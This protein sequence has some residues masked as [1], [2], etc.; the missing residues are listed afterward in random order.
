MFLCVPFILFY[1]CIVAVCCWCF[2][3][4][5]YGQC[6][7]TVQLNQ[8]KHATGGWHRDARRTHIP[9]RDSFYIFLVQKLR[10]ELDGKHLAR[11]LAKMAETMTNG[12]QVPWCFHVNWFDDEAPVYKQAAACVVDANMQFIIMCWWLYDRDPD[13]AHALYLYC[14]RAWQ[15]LDIH[16]ANDALF[17]RVGASWEYS[18]Q[19]KGTLLLTN[20]LMIQTI[21]CMELIHI[22]EKDA[23]KPTQFKN[24][25]ARAVSTWMPEIYK[26]QETLPRVLAVCFN[27][28]PATFVKSF[29]QDM[30]TEWIPCRVQGP[31]ANTPTRAA[32]IYGYADMHD[33]LV[34]P[35][36]GFLWIVVLDA[37]NHHDLAARWWNAYMH[38]HEPKTLYDVYS[39]KTRRPLRRAFL[40]AHPEHALTI[41]TWLTAKNV[42]IDQLI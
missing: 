22:V 31:V 20:V 19:H 41:A 5:E 11:F 28:V 26:T 38:F 16:I 23:R 10:N 34:W 13:K 15:W 18:R 2:K 35:W 33:S 7:F 39:P 25:H 29:N 6:D 8:L 3:H 27:I 9:V 32:W 1:R 42:Q 36:I 37:R 30:H 4:R 21:R 40:K 17:E 14:Q 24:M 12:G